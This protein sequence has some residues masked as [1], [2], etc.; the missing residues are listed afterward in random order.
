MKLLYPSPKLTNVI[1]VLIKAILAIILFVAAFYSVAHAQTTSSQEL[2]F[3]NGVL[4]S[5]TAGA[6]NA[7]YR[8]PSVMTGIDGLVKINGRSSSM[9]QLVT[10]DLTTT[11]FEKA[12]QPQVTYGN[13]NTS[14]AGNTDWWMEF[15]IS[16]V[17]AGTNTAASVSAFDVTGLDIDGNN[18]KISEYQ[19]YY[20]LQ[21]YTLESNTVLK[22]STIQDLV[23]GLLTNVAKRF[24]GTTKTC[25]GVDTSVT[26]CMTT[27][28][29]V[30]TNSF[31]V[32]TGAKSTGVSGAADRMYSL[33]FKSFAYDQ[34][35]T[36]L[37]PVTLINWNAA[38]TNSIIALKWTTTSET[39]SSHFIVERSFDGVEYSDIAML[40]AA[41][42]SSISINY[43]YSD[44]IPANNSGIIYYRLKMVD[45]DGRYKASD[46]RIVRIGKS[47]DGVKILAYPNPVVND[48]RITIPQNWQGKTVS[49]QLS[50]ANGQVIRSYTVQY[51][52]QTEVIA[53][54]QVPAGMYIMRV[55]N[56]SETAVQSVVKS[57]R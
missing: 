24:D 50:N 6:N 32:R 12:F 56:G 51:A 25:D 14:P 15:Q 8:F 47:A 35:I 27:N 52:S 44:K 54:S 5:G 2:V 18:D 11:G 40:F 4:Q 34:G 39:N 28:K 26:A 45:M 16:F 17:K 42:N 48:V 20:G 33:W 21:S 36:N 19:T 29:Y 23:N 31:K 9:V 53:M 38:Y 7:V 43:S 49:Y 22:V 3:R 41:G 10:I 57:A 1:F 55:T 30:N 13:N 46:V 37:L